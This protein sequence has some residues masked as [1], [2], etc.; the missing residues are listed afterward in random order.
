[1]NLSI[2]SSSRRYVVIVL[3]LLLTF[4]GGAEYVS[5]AYIIPVPNTLASTVHLM[6]TETNPDIVLGDSHIYHGFAAEEEFLN[7]GMGG[8]S[9]PRLRNMADHYYMDIPPGKVI[10]QAS[11][12]LLGASRLERGNTEEMF[13]LWRHSPVLLYA[14]DPAIGGPL[15]R[16]RSLTDLRDLKED[17]GSFERNIEERGAWHTLPTEKREDLTGRRVVWQRPA[18]NNETQRHLDQYRELIAS[19]KDRGAEICLLRTPTDA[20]Y[21]ESIEG[22]PD[23]ARAETEFRKIADDF[24]IKYVDAWDLGMNYTFDLFWNQDHLMPDASR[25]FSA[26]AK[27]ACFSE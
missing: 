9:I 18:W 20:F 10:L 16:V 24:G 4:V 1:M 23:Y 17:I 15:K 11:P 12:Q 19:L 13:T 3:G 14:L 26:L 5:R 8:I 6:Y 7:L 22:D 2:A 21:R 25:R 27:Q